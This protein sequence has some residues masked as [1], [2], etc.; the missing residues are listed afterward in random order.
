MVGRLR[1]DPS[2]CPCVSIC[3]SVHLSTYPLSV[4]PSTC[5]PFSLS[6]SVHQS[7]CSS[8]HLSV[9]LL[10]ICP[11]L[12]LSVCPSVYLP[13]LLSVCFWPS[14][15]LLF[16]PSV[17]PSFVYL[18]VPLSVCLSVRPSARACTGEKR[19]SKGMEN[20]DSLVTLKLQTRR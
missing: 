3:P 9:H 4:H 8:V 18:S 7:V 5:L 2:V 1:L 6:V 12:C 10:S 19:G 17:C 13:D 14:V 16:C 15:C 20:R 11:S